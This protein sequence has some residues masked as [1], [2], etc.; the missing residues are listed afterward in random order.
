MEKRHQSGDF[1]SKSWTW[2]SKSI[3]ASQDRSLIVRA[4]TA[5]LQHWIPI[6]TSVTARDATRMLVLVWRDRVRAM[7]VI[8]RMF[9]IISSTPTPIVTLSI[10]FMSSKSSSVQPAIS[11]ALLDS[12]SVVSTGRGESTRFVEVLSSKKALSSI[13]GFLERDIS[14]IISLC[15]L[16]A[17]AFCVRYTH[18]F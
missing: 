17:L 8:S 3:V 7:T 12:P 13:V 1:R 15:F 5:T 2:G 18:N 16:I 11:F 6:R 9:S 4:G 10:P 14:A